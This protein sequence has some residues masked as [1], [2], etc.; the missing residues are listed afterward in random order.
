MMAANVQDRINGFHA[1]F[2]ITR[3]YRIMSKS[4]SFIAPYD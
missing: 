3:I 4:V 1:D 2:E